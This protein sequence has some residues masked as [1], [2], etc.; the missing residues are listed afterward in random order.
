MVPA[1]RRWRNMGIL[2]VARGRRARVARKVSFDKDRP[3]FPLPR[4][5]RRARGGVRWCVRGR[6]AQQYF[7]TV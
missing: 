5:A 7:M 2:A 3:P 4:P 6:L 1:R